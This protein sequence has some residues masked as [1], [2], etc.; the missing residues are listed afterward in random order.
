MSDLATRVLDARNGDVDAYGEL[1]LRFQDMAYAC[2]VAYL[3]DAHAAQDAVQEAFLVA[4]LD[5]QSGKLNDPAAFPGWLK[6]IVRRQCMR[7]TRREE[8]KTQP[9]ETAESLAAPSVD[10]DASQEQSAHR[11]AAMAALQSLPEAHRLVTV[12]YYFS[13]YSTEQIAGITG[14]PLTT[15]KKRLHDARRKL[16][17]WVVKAMNENIQ[18]STPSRDPKFAEKIKRMIQPEQLKKNE[19]LEWSGGMGTDLWE[20]FCAAMSGDLETIQRL[21]EKEPALSRATYMYRTPLHFAVR[22]NQLE[23]AALLIERGADPMLGLGVYDRPLEIAR[24]RGYTQMFKLLETKM[25][26]AH[27]VSPKGAVMVSAIRERNLAKVRSLLDADPELLKTAD[28]RG[29]LPI[30]WAVMTRQPDVIDELLARG[31]DI[32]AARPDGAQ[33]IQLNNGD[34]YFRGGR[35]VPKD[36]PSPAAVYKHLLLRGAQCDIC[37]A[38]AMGEVERVKELLHQDRSLANRLSRYP[39]YYQ[40]SGAPL[41]NA[42]AAGNSEIVKLLLD[43]GA[44]PNLPEPGIA[45]RGGAVYAAAAAGHY[46][47]TKLLLER[48]G[49]ACSQ[50]ES[51]G[52]ALSRAINNGDKK[53][54]EL[55]ASFGAAQ[56]LD[57]LAYYGDVRTA[58]AMFAIDP[59]LA[60]DPDSLAFAAEEGQDAFVRLMLRYQPTLAER[61]A[62]HPWESCAK[63]R[64]LNELL[65]KHGANPSQPNWLRVTPLH[66]FAQKGDVEKATIFLDCGADLNARDDEMCSTPL[67]WAARFGQTAMVEFL[68]KRGATPNLPDDAPW[69]T[70]LAWATRKGHAKIV[71]ILSRHGAV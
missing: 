42:A 9:I 59:S 65:F 32:N 44:D 35:D 57:I 18:S 17:Q 5:L 60:D 27:G 19:H 56:P 33:P 8:I 68:L 43:H 7:V 26:S 29:N 40:C 47:I 49:N 31:A 45:P 71:E 1:V 70:P 15:V 6:T 34:Y 50:V 22:E 54:V 67:G 24:D 16:Q 36:A 61:I 62:W 23:A 64:E 66:R 30:H 55:L 37:T 21:L 13:G 28:E 4:F 14:V 38:A 20:L 51:S 2:A 11:R 3:G 39:G 46:E 25:S 53:M 48:G 10:V 63:T 58:A 41:R 52:D 12:L 69:A